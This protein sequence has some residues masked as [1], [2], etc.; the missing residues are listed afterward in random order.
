MGEKEM[1]EEFLGIVSEIPDDPDEMVLLSGFINE[2]MALSDDPVP[3]EEFLAVITH[4][5]PMIASYMNLVGGREFKRLLQTKMSLEE[6]LTR[7]KVDVKYF[8]QL[9]PE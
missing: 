6:A 1:I 2:Q 7:L 4:R 5:L 9:P 8:E 3:L